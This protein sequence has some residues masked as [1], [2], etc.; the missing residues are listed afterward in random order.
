MFEFSVSVLILCAANVA[1][2]WPALSC[3]TMS[4]DESSLQ[5]E[6]D[7]L[8]E[9]SCEC[10]NSKSSPSCTASWG[11]SLC[12][13]LPVHG[14]D[15]SLKCAKIQS[16]Y[17]RNWSLVG[18][19]G[20]ETFRG[21]GDNGWQN[22]G[23]Y[24]GLNFGTR[25]GALSD[26]TGI[27]FQ[28]G[29]TLGLYDWEGSP[30]RPDYDS[31]MRQ[32]FVSYGFFRRATESLPFALGI[33]QDWMIA[34]NFGGYG[35]SI[36]VSQIRYR[37]GYV[38]SASNEFGFLGT[39][40]VHDHAGVSGTQNVQIRGV[41]H[42]SAFWHHKWFAGGPNTTITLGSAEDDRLRDNGSLGDFLATA[43]IQAPMSE[44][45]GFSGNIMYMNPTAT[46]GMDAA[47]E[48]AWSFTL[49]IELFPGSDARSTTIAG[50]KWMALLPIANNG[51]FL[52]DTAAWP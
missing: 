2:E 51:V 22:N 16:N 17:R 31:T 20:Y 19:F 35:Q 27:G 28:V 24:S 5:N 25:L 15:D 11:M 6:C 29:G 49:G 44:K 45:L 37:F 21:V 14:G 8:I 39:A 52:L 9:S 13:L 48:E 18:S 4:C 26:W 3:Q 30:Y 47:H 36:E 41:N 50:E 34:D 38:T 10:L 46:S 40:R 43:T 23:L 33:T 32:D 7:R 1:A 12:D 42:L